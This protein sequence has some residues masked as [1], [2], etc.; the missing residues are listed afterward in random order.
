TPTGL[1]ALDSQTAYNGSYPR[2]YTTY[3]VRLYH[4]DAR[5]GKFTYSYPV[6]WYFNGYFEPTSLDL[7]GNNYYGIA[8]SNTPSYSADEEYRLIHMIQAG[9]TNTF[10]TGSN[11]SNADLFTTGQTFSMS[12]YG[13]QFFKN[14]T[15]LNNGNPLGYTI[16]FVNVSA[17]SATIRILVA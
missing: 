13:S 8:H 11:G 16:Q 5:I 14:N 6:G 2:G 9:G 3:G 1:N 7:S 4:V 10:D 15:L 17:T 12:T